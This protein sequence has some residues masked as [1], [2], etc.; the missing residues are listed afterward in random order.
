MKHCIIVDMQDLMLSRGQRSVRDGRCI[1]QAQ[2]RADAMALASCSVHSWPFTYV[3]LVRLI[4][5]G[6]DMASINHII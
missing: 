3:R 1:S 6:Y 2:L 4:E 5:D